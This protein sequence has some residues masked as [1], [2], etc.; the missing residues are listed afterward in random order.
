MSKR[1]TGRLIARLF[2]DER[3]SDR[4]LLVAR[5]S[6]GREGPLESDGTTRL[7]RWREETQLK[8]GMHLETR[9]WSDL[10][11]DLGGFKLQN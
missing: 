8:P 4:K 7:S 10:E 3:L 6:E 2:L 1:A 11:L 5:E 9:F